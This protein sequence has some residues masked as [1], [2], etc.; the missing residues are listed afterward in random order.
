MEWHDMPMRKDFAAVY[1]CGEYP[2]G[3]RE[4][5]RAWCLQHGTIPNDRFFFLGDTCDLLDPASVK[6]WAE[7]IVEQLKG[8]R[9]VIFVDTWQ[10]AT[11][12]GDQ[13]DNVLMQTATHHAVA[14]GRSVKG[15]VVFAAHPPKS[16]KESNILTVMGSGIIENNSSGIWH[17]T[18]DGGTRTLTVDRVKSKG[19]GNYEAFK[20]V[21]RDLGRTDPHFNRRLTAVYPERIAGSTTKGSEVE[22]KMLEAIKTAYGE[23]IRDLYLEVARRDAEAGKAYNLSD[24]CPAFIRL[25]NDNVRVKALQ[26]LNQCYSTADSL[27]SH[28]KSM[29]TCVPVQVEDVIMNISK[30]GAVTWTSA[31]FDAP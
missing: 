17:L 19:K 29:L 18:E 16:A 4:M 26:E 25:P 31:G 22:T 6:I 12:Q 23:A 27:N 21:Q 30:R 3:A 15:P 7:F 10:Q 14:L 28:L 20:F 11:A 24:F 1:I 9:A 2:I 5:F 8:R 13:S